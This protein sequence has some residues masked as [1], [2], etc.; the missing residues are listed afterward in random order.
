M[1]RRASTDKGQWHSFHKCHCMDDHPHAEGRPCND[2]YE[3]SAIVPCQ[4]TRAASF[5]RTTK[6]TTMKM[7]IT[8]PLPF[9]AFSITSLL[10]FSTADGQRSGI[11][12]VD[13]AAKS[14]ASEQRGGT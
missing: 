5:S 1:K 9:I 7:N 3:R 6:G 13:A 8:L 4:S 12:S 10:L 14:A 2:I 11:K